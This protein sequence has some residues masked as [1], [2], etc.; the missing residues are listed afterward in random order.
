MVFVPPVATLRSSLTATQFTSITLG[1][2]KTFCLVQGHLM[3][4]DNT[5]LTDLEVFGSS[6]RPGVFELVARTSTSIGRSALRRRMERPASDIHEI[7]ATQE[8]VSFLM[9]HHEVLQFDNVSV[10]AVTRYLR[11]NITPSARSTLG[12]RLEYVWWRLNYRDVLREIEEGVGATLSLFECLDRICATLQHNNPP[13]L[14]SEIVTPIR[15][16]AQ[17]LVRARADAATILVVDRVFRSILKPSIEEALQS[18]AELDALTAM[19]LTTSSQGWVFP[20]LDDAGPFLLEADDLR[21]PFLNDGVANPI[22]LSGGEPMVFLTGPNMAGKTTYLRTV[23]LSVL[24]GQ[25]GMGIPA[26][27]ARLSPIDVLFTSLNPTDNLRAGLSYFYAEVLRVKAAAAILV[28]G[29]R[30]LIIFDE[31][32]KGTNVRD[33]LDASS[34]VILGFAKARRSGFIFSSHLIELVTTLQ[35]NPS[36]RFY[37]FDGDIEHG[38][39]RYSFTLREGFSDKRFGLLLLRQADV[40]EMLARISA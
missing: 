31:V 10:A 15:A 20:D 1:R 25:M 19:A 39:P 9:I 28:E 38:V 27:K 22:R 6:G 2:N 29:K 23:A 35:S 7:R 12:D 14:I 17:Q 5:T 34:E 4:I 3:D 40:P 11:S 16:A 30:S 18:L 32:F 33:A 26:S 36:I 24:L 13:R 8:A 21:H 37:C